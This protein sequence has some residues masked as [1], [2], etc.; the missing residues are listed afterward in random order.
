[1]IRTP[2]PIAIYSRIWRLLKI[3]SGLTKT[4]FNAFTNRFLFPLSGEL[5]TVTSE[6]VPLRVRPND[7]HGR[8]LLIH[9]T[10]DRKVER[11]AC[12][13]A[14][15]SDIFLD[16]GANYS[17]IGLA[18][19]N[20][21]GRSGHVH[22]FEPQPWLVSA[23][24]EGIAARSISNVTMHDVAL[25]DRDGVLTLRAPAYHSG[26]ATLI[27]DDAVGADW[28]EFQVPTRATTPYLSPILA[29]RS[30]GVK[31]DVEGAEETIL[32]EL[33]KFPN[34]RY[35]VFEGCNNERW[36]FDNF[37]LNGFTIYGLERNPIVCRLCRV[38]DFARWHDFHDFI[39]VPH[40]GVA[41]PKR[42]NRTDL[43]TL[44]RKAG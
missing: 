23:V 42:S 34:F 21:V 3:N 35:C 38:D 12:A 9:G 43:A 27:N 36:L 19:A 24:T 28:I 13:F 37:R 30:F 18:V 20:V 11:V 2:V 44:V 40:G 29:N 4:A 25:F 16:I 17:T 26:M 8:V 14:R 6:G 31:I 39:A 32:T 5:M 1:M 33:F 10:N 41:L 7:Y 15:S 22:L